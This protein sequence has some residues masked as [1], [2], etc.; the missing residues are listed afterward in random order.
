MELR[1]SSVL[2]NLSDDRNFMPTA[3]DATI[4]DTCLV[5]QVTP[6]QLLNTNLEPFQ[7]VMRI[8]DACMAILTFAEAH[9][10][11]QPDF[12]GP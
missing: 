4:A 10:H 8:Y 5:T 2:Q 1:E 3:E 12:E 11:R 7:T 6:A 9:P